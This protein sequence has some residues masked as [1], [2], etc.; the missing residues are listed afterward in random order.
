MCLTDGTCECH[1]SASTE[2]ERKKGS[3]EEREILYPARFTVFEK[4]IPVAS[5]PNQLF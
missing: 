3:E 4:A 1:T 5:K 2:N